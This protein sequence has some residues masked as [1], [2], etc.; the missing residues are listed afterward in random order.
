MLLQS[1]FFCRQT[2]N[3]KRLV[4]ISRYAQRF[5]MQSDFNF[6]FASSEFCNIRYI[7]D[8]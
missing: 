4:T 6:D 3:S 2:K 1:K 8:I 5:F 7:N